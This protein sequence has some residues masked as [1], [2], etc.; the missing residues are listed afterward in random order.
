MS[1]ESKKQSIFEKL[2]GCHEMRFVQFKDI[3]EQNS[4]YTHQPVQVDYET[5]KGREKQPEFPFVDPPAED[6]PFYDV[7]L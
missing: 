3:S 1:Q 4:K 5:Y 7:S 6:R 2:K